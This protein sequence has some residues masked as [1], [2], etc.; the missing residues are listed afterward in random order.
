M[1]C[2]CGHDMVVVGTVT[3]S[4]QLLC[5]CEDRGDGG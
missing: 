5:K 4:V 3:G 2:G 1:S